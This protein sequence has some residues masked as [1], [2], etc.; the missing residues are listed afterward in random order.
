LAADDLPKLFQPFS[1]IG[2]VGQG[3]HTGTGLGLF[4][5]RGIV[6]GHGGKIWVESAGPGRGS[7]F[8]IHL[9]T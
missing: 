5:C 1:Q 9:P 4:I 6:E 8:F 2:V 3:K 7:T